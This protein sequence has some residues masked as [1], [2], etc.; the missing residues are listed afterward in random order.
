M[1]A[2]TRQWNIRLA[3]V[4]ERDAETPEQCIAT[5]C[6][7]IAQQGFG[8]HTEESAKKA[9][10]IAHRVG[11]RA[12]VEEKGQPRHIIVRFYS[13]MTKSAVLRDAK[14]KKGPIGIFEDMTKCDYNNKQL[15]KPKMKVIWEKGNY[16]K[17]INGK[18]V[19]GPART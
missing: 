8:G 17:F 11:R 10:E 15:A 7:Y 12:G 1:E 19:V 4:R 2:Y 13:R 6:S 14:R 5:V 9:I 18:I 3:G 16:V